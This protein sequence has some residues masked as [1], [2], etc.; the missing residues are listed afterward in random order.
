M[1]ILGHANRDFDL[2]GDW[3]FGGGT[4]L[5]LQ[6]NH[7]ESHD[8]DLFIRDPQ[9][10]PYLNPEN[11]GYELVLAPDSYVSDGAVSLKILFD[12]IG[13]IDF[14]CCEP[15]L[16]ED[17][18]RRDVRGTSVLVE[19]PAEIVAK[20]VYHRG[21]RLQPRDMFDIAAVSRT[22]GREY[23]AHPL[24]SIPDRVA[25]ALEVV[26]SYRSQL[27]FPVFSSLN[28]NSGFEDIPE[29]AQD[30]T[31]KILRMALDLA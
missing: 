5:M 12:G 24:S 13:E 30:E 28:V 29:C 8:V 17:S 9:I 25:S 21:S 1:A 4:A 10:L 7:R 15:I 18:V 16:N 20:K 14:I 22:M 11:Q 23:L 26:V 2:V 3:T 27:I 6:I 19:T 31:V